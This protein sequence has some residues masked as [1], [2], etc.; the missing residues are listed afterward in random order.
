[1]T[2]VPVK[3]LVIELAVPSTVCMLVTALY[4]MADTF[5]IGKISTQATGAIGIVF[6]Y[7]ALIQSIAFFFGHGSGNYISRE[8]G[9]KNGENAEK[10]AAFGFFSAFAVGVLIAVLG[11][12]F[13]NP[14][15]RLFGATETILPEARPYFFYIL[16]ATPFIMTTFVMN[17]HMRFQGNANKAMFGIL[18]GAVLNVILDPILIFGAGLGIRGASMATAVSQIAGFF[19]ML[20]MTGKGGGIKIRLA[21]FSFSWAS[22]CEV[23]AGGLPSLGRQGLMSVSAICLNHAA[24]IYGDSAIAAFSVVSRATMIANSVVIGIGQGFQPV[25][26]FNYGAGRFDRVREAVRFSSV[27]VTALLVV[28]GISGGI[29]AEQIVRVFRDDDLKLIEIA[30]FALRAQCVT[31]PLLGGITI[32][33]MYLQNIRKTLPATIVAVSRQ[34]VFL[35]AALLLLGP[36]FGIRGVQLAQ[37]AADAAAF[38]LALPLGIYSIKGMGRDAA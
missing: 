33:N 9:R 12:V 5:F 19:V 31:F 32:T 16:L 15:L 1:M 29:F 2:A 10:M 8:L 27:L 25:C 24:G 36:L 3:Q 22:L 20:H 18:T 17:N 13:M 4:N 23:A 21:N 6:T 28:F 14:A 35:I 34:G 11:F 30:V 7:M 37:P 38:L 26:G